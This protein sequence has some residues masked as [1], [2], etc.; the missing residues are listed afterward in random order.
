MEKTKTCLIAS[1]GCYDLMPEKTLAEKLR[2][3]RFYRLNTLKEAGEFFD[4][5]AHTFIAW[6]K[7]R[8]AVS[9]DIFDDWLSILQ[10]PIEPQWD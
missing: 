8:T 3:A 1:I 4:V 6:E 9:R 5:C 10:I 7:G 2:K